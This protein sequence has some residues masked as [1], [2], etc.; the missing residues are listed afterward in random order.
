[1]VTTQAYN[2]TSTFYQPQCTVIS[3]MHSDKASGVS[4]YYMKI[5]QLPKEY[6]DG[7]NVSSLILNGYI[8]HAYSADRTYVNLVMGNRDEG[9]SGNF[10]CYGVYEDHYNEPIRIIRMAVNKA[11]E[12]CLICT[13]GYASL[14][15]IASV[16]GK[17]AID[18]KRDF[19]P[20]DT[21]WIYVSDVINE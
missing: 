3:D 15:L 2:I 14:H 4:K 20:T 16:S 6:L 21:N 11:Y 13:T 1:M 18:Y 17:A 8:G 9:G 10:K 7:Q 12:V 5:A 19:T